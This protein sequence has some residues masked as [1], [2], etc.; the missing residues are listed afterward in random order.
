VLY[1]RKLPM[2]DRQGLLAALVSHQP[3]VDMTVTVDC[4]G[5]REEQVI[6]LGWADLFQP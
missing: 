5:C 1:A 3:K 4:V 6:P 2:R